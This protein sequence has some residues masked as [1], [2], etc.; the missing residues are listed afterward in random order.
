[1]KMLRRGATP[2]DTLSAALA[3][4][5]RCRNVSQE[6]VEIDDIDKKIVSCYTKENETCV[7]ETEIKMENKLIELLKKISTLTDEE[8]GAFLEKLQSVICQET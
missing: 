5:R 6:I 1:M 3:W 4:R 2:Q 7:R 8:C